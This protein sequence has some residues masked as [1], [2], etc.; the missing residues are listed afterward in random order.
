MTTYIVDDVY[1]SENQICYSGSTYADIINYLLN[2]GRYDELYEILYHEMEN[3]LKISFE[4]KEMRFFISKTIESLRNKIGSYRYHKLEM[5][6][7]NKEIDILNSNVK[8]VINK[9][10]KTKF[11]KLELSNVIYSIKNA[12]FHNVLEYDQDNKE[13]NNETN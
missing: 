11:N 13:I 4:K 5:K 7:F 1:R 12:P 2:N 9:T 6:F 8:Y 3:I 10:N